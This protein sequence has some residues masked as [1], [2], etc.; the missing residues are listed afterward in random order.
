MSGKSR[1]PVSGIGFQ[2]VEIDHLG[3][4]VEGSSGGVVLARLMAYARPTDPDSPYC[5]VN[6]AVSTRLGLAMGVDV[7]QGGL[8]KLGTG[9]GFYSAGFG[10]QGKRPPPADL[11]ALASERPWETTGIIVFDQWI[12]NRDRHDENVAYLPSLGVAAIDHDQALFGACPPGDGAT[13]LEQSKDLRVKQH[14]FAEHLTTDAY[15]EQWIARA[16]S[17]THEELRRAVWSCVDAELLNRSDAETLMSFLQH[18]Q[19]SVGRFI[20]ESHSEF[21]KIVAWTLGNGGG[22]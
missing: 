7:P 21:A 15:F 6:D 13:S 10:E 22:E 4:V 11:E 12:S 1:P 14:P 2:A 18:R 9:Y 19:R 20:E 5:V 8:I 17:V 16:K 3:A